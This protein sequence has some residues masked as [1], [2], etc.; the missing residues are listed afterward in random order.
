VIGA[1]LGPYEI[2]ASVGAGGMGEVYRAHD[3]RLGRDV[4]I[5]VLP[6]HLIDSSEALARF[7]REA[8]AVAAL[9]HP[10][11]LALHDVG[12]DGPV[13]YAVTELLEGETVRARM[14]AGPI[15][16][17]RALDILAQIARGLG[18]AHERGIVHRDI[19]PENLF[20]TSDGHLKILDFGVAVRSNGV[21]TGVNPKSAGLTQPGMIVGTPAY[22]APEQLL[23]QPATP[24][25][26]L[27]AFGLVAHELLTGSHP[28]NR[29]T[30]GEMLVAILR[31]D[32]APLGPVADA[33]PAGVALMLGR[34]LEKQP[35]DRPSSARDLAIYLETLGAVPMPAASS[36]G[37]PIVL[38]A[39]AVPM[40]RQRVL[41]SAIALLLLVV[42]LTWGY[43]GIMAERVA[44]DVI[45][46]DLT[47]A[48]RLVRRVHGERFERL[49]L[50]AE[51]I[52]A[53]PDFKAATGTDAATVRDVLATHQ[54]SHP[55]SEVLIALL[56]DGRVLAR[57]DRAT[58]APPTPGDTWLDTFVKQRADAAVVA[59]DGRLHHA[60]AATSSAADTPFGWVIV[61]DPVDA[62]F[63]RALGEATQ[64]E[65]VLLGSG[66]LGTTITGADPPWRSRE[67]WRERGGRPDRS[68]EIDIG[69]QRFAAREVALSE[70]PAL[71]A[72]VAK[73]R[74]AI[75]APF[76]SIQRGLLVIGL[77]CTAVALAGAFWVAR[78]TMRAIAPRK[79][80]TRSRQS[81][82]GD[83]RN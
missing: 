5:K 39:N 81:A 21:E 43:A 13:S 66:V 83:P 36:P 6:P 23:A 73:S 16:P 75:V 1:R 34:C 62:E 78:S 48:E 3:T 63:A 11:I 26:D 17:R 35:T 44:N 80:G 42:G 7:E 69:S 68:T 67:D 4:A 29:Q 53:S 30:S 28:F 15:P 32:P 65:I 22:M 49:T 55:G 2:L 70:Q 41:L 20:L 51:L 74:D 82:V 77:L 56:P 71:S 58:A 27:F 25:S 45:E 59:I 54:A 47:R 31:D 12:R 46:N 19:K 50:V 40:V 64:D 9:N 10:N 38:P 72:V 37:G 18:A 8:R 60:A 61:A 57:T 14:S 76:K 33:L 79:S 52:A 24:R